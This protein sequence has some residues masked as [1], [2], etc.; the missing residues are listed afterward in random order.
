MVLETDEQA[1]VAGREMAPELVP[2]SDL[3][4]TGRRV[5]ISLRNVTDQPVK[6]GARMLVEQV[7]VAT[8]VFLKKLK[9]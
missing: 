5:P 2:T 4:R 1:R 7:S 3:L 9:I 6:L 8:P